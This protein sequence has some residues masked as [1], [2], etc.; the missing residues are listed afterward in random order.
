[1]TVILAAEV[2]FEQ[3]LQDIA[4]KF[5]ESTKFWGS[6]QLTLTLA[7]R[8]LTPEQEFQI[9][10]MIMEHSQIEIMCLMDMDLSLIHI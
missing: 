2:P 7:G 6:I 10:N 1:M 3:L 9:A 4:I 8:S 5:E